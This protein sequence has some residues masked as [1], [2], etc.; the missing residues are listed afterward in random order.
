MR[1]I[2]VGDIHM[3]WSICARIPGIGSAD[4]L[5][6]TGDLTNFG[7]SRDAER[8]LREMRQCNPNI[9]ALAG[10]LDHPEVAA[11]LS[12][13]GI[14]LHGLGRQW[15]GLG[16][17]G[18]GGSNPTPF[19]T[20]FELTE[21]E[22]GALLEQGFQQVQH[23]DTLLLITHAPPH[24]TATDRLAS[25]AHVGST[26]IRS[27]IEE[28]QPAAC[29]CGHIHE[30]KAMDRIGATTILNHGMLKNGGYVVV[31]SDNGGVH[32]RLENL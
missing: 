2:A 32:A 6:I 28:H 31:T 22:L 10:N 23:C 3:D 29:I 30:A 27:F 26:A 5:I 21:K 18:A 25:G 8:V 9:L 19:N 13:H 17:L 14:S 1:L 12:D 20:P 16:L 11:L 15:N 7:S 4:L 24:A